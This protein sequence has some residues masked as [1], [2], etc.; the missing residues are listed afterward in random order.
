MNGII[1]HVKVE[2][3]PTDDLERLKKAVENII[4]NVEFEVKLQNR[5]SLLTA[6]AKGIDT[7]FF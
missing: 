3:N 5:G 1:I 7:V 2:V 6:K 4:W